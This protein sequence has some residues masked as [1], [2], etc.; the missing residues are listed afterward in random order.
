M[1]FIENYFVLKS[2]GAPATKA[3]VIQKKS[4]KNTDEDLI[5]KFEL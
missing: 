4:E 3:I 5:F 1:I 2:N